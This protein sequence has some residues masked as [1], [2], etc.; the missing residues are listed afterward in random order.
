MASKVGVS[1]QPPINNCLHPGNQ[2]LTNFNRDWRETGYALNEDR[3]ITHHVMFRPEQSQQ[4]MHSISCSDNPDPRS[5]LLRFCSDGAEE[6]R[7][8]SKTQRQIYM[9]RL[10]PHGGVMIIAP[11]GQPGDQI[12]VAKS[13][14]LPASIRKLLSMARNQECINSKP[15]SYASCNV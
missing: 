14:Q 11:G 3:Q 9:L 15:V 12:P 4:L 13:R 2:M 1:Y 5:G 10:K 8:F 7:Q 6:S